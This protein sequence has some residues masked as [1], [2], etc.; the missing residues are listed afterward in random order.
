MKTQTV[1]IQEFVRGL[2]QIPAT[3]FGPQTVNDFIALHRIEPASLASYLFFS[4]ANYTRN[5]VSK[6]DLF[7]LLAICWEV[8]QVSRIHNHRDQQ[9]WMAVPIGTLENQNYRVLDRNPQRGTCRL[10]PSA[11]L[12]ITPSTPL[13]VDPDEPVHQVRNRPEYA[14]RAVSIHIYSRPFDTCEVYSLEQGNYY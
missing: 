7:E 3:R 8:G 5:L 13:A 2:E 14:A 12:L 6:N 1:T 11:T 4:R 10:E 9:C